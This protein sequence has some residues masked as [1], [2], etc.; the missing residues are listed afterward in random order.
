MTQSVPE[1][2]H[3]CALQALHPLRKYSVL[4]AETCTDFMKTF[5]KA[6]HFEWK[7][8]KWREPQSG[9]H[10]TSLSRWPSPH[11]VPLPPFQHCDES[12]PSVTVTNRGYATILAQ[13][14]KPRRLAGLCSEGLPFSRRVTN[15]VC[16]CLGPSFLA[17]NRAA[18]VPLVGH[19]RAKHVTRRC[20][21]TE[22]CER[23]PSHITSEMQ[24]KGGWNVSVNICRTFS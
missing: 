14:R 5:V 19:A 11:S 13:S 17:P 10:L 23:S 12:P 18:V 20:T 9:R 6:A 3:I 24:T 7:N 2:L 15:K 21:R 8:L 16:H 1:A 4:S 22:A